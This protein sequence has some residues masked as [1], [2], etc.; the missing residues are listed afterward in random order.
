MFS[1]EETIDKRKQNMSSLIS[2]LISARTGNQPVKRSNNQQS[3][4]EQ[5]QTT[6]QDETL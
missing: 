2:L 6:S 3:S 4:N 5:Q 1:K